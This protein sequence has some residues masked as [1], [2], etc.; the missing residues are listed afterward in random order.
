MQAPDND[1]GMVVIEFNHFLMHFKALVGNFG[2]LK[3]IFTEAYAPHGNFTPE[4]NT[5]LIKH[6]NENLGVGIV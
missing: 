4:E 3:R 6:I 5:A 1:G 2:I